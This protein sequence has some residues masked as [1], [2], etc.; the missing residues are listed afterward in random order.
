MSHR[1][2]SRCLKLDEKNSNNG[3]EAEVG[4]DQKD[5]GKDS[6][7]ADKNEE[8]EKSKPCKKAK[9]E[10]VKKS[11]FPEDW[12]I[13]AG[14]A[15]R[16]FEHLWEVAA[17][18]ASIIK[19][20]TGK[21]GKLLEIF[22]DMKHLPRN[23]KE[24]S[25]EG[26]LL[27]TRLTLAVSRLLE[28]VARGEDESR[29]DEKACVTL[30]S[31]EAWGDLCGGVVPRLIDFIQQ[32]D[33]SGQN[34]ACLLIAECIE[35]CMHMLMSGI[36][37]GYTPQ[38]SD[39]STLKRL[40]KCQVEKKSLLEDLD[41][42][43]GHAAVLLGVG[44]PLLEAPEKHNFL[45][46]LLG[47]VECQTCSSTSACAALDAIFEAFAED[48]DRPSLAKCRAAERL[49][50]VRTARELHTDNEGSAD[51]EDSGTRENLAAFL[52]YL[53]EHKVSE[54]AAVEDGGVDADSKKK[55]A[56]E[57]I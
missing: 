6:K 55:A 26:V 5:G 30:P 36:E 9:K 29:E 31:Q 53:R 49:E 19:K 45:D 57:D 34:D 14:V 23:F 11:V 28:F 56:M 54:A 48:A 47:L 25:N 40:A 16:V 3:D 2:I 15:S 24:L 52:A 13:E 50:K 20:L 1:P 42:A 51:E 12:V 41:T 44:L 37:H 38:K 18:D 4:S 43:R 10:K 17:N 8:T 21:D 35:S 46:P 39:L 22:L 27:L 32:C 7:N 33:R